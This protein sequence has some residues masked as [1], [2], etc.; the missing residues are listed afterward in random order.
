ME[1]T[2]KTR[3]VSLGAVVMIAPLALAG[4][5]DALSPSHVEKP[6]ADGGTV[7]FDLAAGEY[8]LRGSSVKTIKANWQTRK[9]SDAIRARVDVVVDGTTARIVSHGPKDG[10]RVDI[11]VPPHTHL[12]LNLSAG[13]LK[14]SRIEGHKNLSVWAGEITVEVGDPNLYKRVDAAV[15]MGELDARPFEV[16]KG[17]LLRSFIR[18]GNGK[19]TFRARLFA[20]ELVMTR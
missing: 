18:D 3:L 7:H 16:S 4:Y 14:I 2:M 5:Q 1:A 12:D 20:G 11:D 15:R 10:F 19:Y 9:P 13:E 17:G 6:F 8:N